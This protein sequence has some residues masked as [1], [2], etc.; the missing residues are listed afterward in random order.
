MGNHVLCSLYGISFS[1][2]NDLDSIQE[3]FDRA[4]AT[5]NATVLNK[6]C[7]KFTPQGVTILY[8]LAESHI[9][10]HTFP[11]IGS[12]SLDCYTCGHMDSQAG[13]KVLIDHF[14]PIETDLKS[15]ER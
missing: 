12:V 1:V 7:H 10:C 2:L 8:A 14:N 4:V 15:V 3:A 6:F 11:E 9:S 13:M 5:M